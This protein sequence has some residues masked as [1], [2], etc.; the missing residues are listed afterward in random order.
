M[1]KCYSKETP[2]ETEFTNGAHAGRADAPKEKGGG[3]TGFNPFELFEAALGGCINIWLRVYAANHGIPLTGIVTEVTA[4]RQTPG[5]TI[6]NYAL[7]LQGPLTAVQRQELNEAAH[8]CPVHQALSGKIS[9]NC[10]SA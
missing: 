1:I 7:E 9:F 2:F 3:E 4:D 6:F 10:T 5:E 8:S